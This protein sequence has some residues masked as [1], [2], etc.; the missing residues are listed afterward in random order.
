[1]YD[2][3]PQAGN[4]PTGLLFSRLKCTKEG[5]KAISWALYA[6][7]GLRKPNENKVQSPADAQEEVA[8]YEDLL[9]LEEATNKL[10]SSKYHASCDLSRP[11]LWVFSLRQDGRSSEEDTRDEESFS[12][13]TEPLELASE[14]PRPAQNSDIDVA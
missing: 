3:C 4:T 6:P 2:Q 7:K 9:H 11:A 14:Q 13:V 1:M 5:I 10:R 12:K 8:S